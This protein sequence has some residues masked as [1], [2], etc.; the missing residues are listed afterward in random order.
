MNIELKYQPSYTLG[1]VTLG[2]G[3]E[4]QVEGGSMVS[5]SPGCRHRN[6]S[7]RRLTQIIGPGGV[8]RRILLPK[9]FQGQFAGRRDHSSPRTA[10]RYACRSIE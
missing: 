7:P 6:Q 4:I 8:G 1:I 5:M 3:E 9:H 10:G 2:P